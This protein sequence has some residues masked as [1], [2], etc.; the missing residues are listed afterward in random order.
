MESKSGGLRRT[1]WGLWA[2]ICIA[3]PGGADAGQGV[4]TSG[5]PYGGYM[6]TLAVDPSNPNA[7]Y[8]GTSGGGVYK[9]TNAGG[10]WAPANSGLTYLDQVSALVVDPTTPATVYAG[11]ASG[12]NSAGGIFRSTNAGGTWASINT[13]LL[14][15][16]VQA[17]AMALSTPATLYAATYGGLFKTVD[18]GTTWADTGLTT[19][20]V[21]AVVVNPVNPATLYAGT[22]GKVYKST[23]SGGT[24]V[25]TGLASLTVMALAIDPLTPTTLFAGT[26]NLGVLKSTDAG[27]TW[28][29]ANSGLPDQNVTG[30]A[31]NPQTPATLY[32][33][34]GGVK[35]Y[36]STDSGGTWVE[37]FS[38]SLTVM[39]LALNPQ[40][41]ATVYVGETGEG[42]RVHKSTD[43]GG[44]W[45]PVATGI[46][47]L[48]LQSIAVA[49]STPGT[50]YAG[51]DGGAFKS[52][53]SGGSWGAPNTSV[54]RVYALAVDPSNPARI[55]AGTYWGIRRSTDAG[56]T[57]ISTS[58]GASTNALA[59]DPS[60][61]NVV[62]A[63]ADNGRVYKSTDS[64]S[65]WAQTTLQAGNGTYALVIDPTAP[66]TIYA[67][68]SQVH[69]S[70]DAGTTWIYSGS[71]LS[72]NTLALAVD[73]GSSAILYAGK[74]EGV[75][76]STN[77]GSTW[78]TSSSG[79]P[80]NPYVVKLTVDPV[81]PSNVYAGT[82][83]G[84]TFKSS[85]AGGTWAP[86]SPGLPVPGVG[87]LLVDPASST[88]YVA[89]KYGSIWQ[90]T[91][92]PATL[93]VADSSALEAS[94]QITF[95][96]SLTSSRG[97]QVT[98]AYATSDGSARAGSD[99]TG[100][101]GVL[102]FPP[103]T[104]SRSVSVP[105]LNDAI[106]EPNETFYLNLS[107][108]S[109]VA[110]A[111]S[112]ATGTIINDDGAFGLSISGASVMEGNSGTAN[113]TFTVTLTP[114]ASSTVT[115]NYQTLSGTATV[116]TDFTLASG[117]LTF[118]PGQTSRPIV[119]P[120]V[121][122]TLPET[123][124]TFTVRL[125]GAVGAVIAGGGQ[126]VG[127]I[128]DDDPGGGALEVIDPACSSGT[129]CDGAV[130]SLLV[131]RT[132]CGQSAFLTTDTVKLQQASVT[133]R[134]VVADGVT[135]LLLRMPSSVPVTFSLRLHD[136]T[137][138][139]GEEVG[140]LMD[141]DAC[142]R[143]TSVTVSPELVSGSN[144][145]F[146][147]YQAPRWTIP[148]SGDVQIIATPQGGGAISKVVE[149]RRPPVVL[150]HGVWSGPDTWRNVLRPPAAPAKWTQLLREAGFDAAE[151][152]L[153]D[154]SATP[155]G[156]FDPVEIY[157]PATPIRALILATR[158]A[159][160]RLRAEHDA[161]VTQVDVVGHSLGGLVARAR[162]KY[163]PSP[164]YMPWNLNKGD[165]HKII[166]IGT[167]HQATP[168]GDLLSKWQC[169]RLASLVGPTLADTLERLDMPMGP[170]IF[171]FQ[172]S[173]W[174]LTIIGPTP[175]PGHS[176]AGT[177]PLISGVEN[178]LNGLLR[179]YDLNETV[180]PLL[181]GEGN[182]DVIVPLA[183]QRGGLS[184]SL[185]S[186]VGGV[187]HAGSPVDI[188]ELNSL[189]VVTEVMRV[190][191]LPTT[192]SNFAAF[193][194]FQRTGT[195]I[196]PYSCPVSPGGTTTSSG[197]LALTPS[198]GEVYRPG[199]PVPFTATL[200]G[201][202]TVDGLLVSLGRGLTT[203]AGPGPWSV[204]FTPTA[205]RGG[206]VDLVA[207]TYG[208]T[209]SY[210]ASTFI[211]VL[212]AGSPIRLTAAPTSMAF[213][214]Q[215]EKAQIHVSGLYDDG[216]E[217]D[218]TSAAAGTTYSSSN[219]AV[220]AVTADG[221]VEAL[222][223]GTA[224][225]SVANGTS[226]AS[227][228]VTVAITNAAPTLSA[229]PRVTM[230]PGQS[231][232]VPVSA[233]DPNGNTL[234]ITGVDLPPFAS[235][236]DH[237]DGTG[238]V[239]LQPTGSDIGTHS[240]LIAVTDDGTP[241]LGAMREL[242]V[243]VRSPKGD[244]DSDSSTDLVFRST[245]N[246]AQN[247]VWLMNGVARASE[248][249]IVPDAASASWKIRG[250]DDFDG[251]GINDLVFWNQATGQVEFWLMN[252]TAREGDPVPLSGGPT[253]ATNWDLA[254]TADFNHDSL[255]D[256]VWRNATSQKIVIW[257]MN[258]T[259]RTGAMIPVPDQAV[260]G[261][262][263]VVGA[264]DYNAD[265]NTD[266]LWYNP[267]SGK[268]VFWFMDAA[269]HRI[270][271]QFANP[272]NAGD[273]NW[274]VLAAGDYGVGPG[275]AEWTQ[276]VVWRN[277]TSGRYV[278]WYMDSAGNRTAGTFTN[279][280]SPASALDWTL[281]GPR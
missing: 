25:D 244:M 126:G 165:I 61:S 229:L 72:T 208:G 253:L 84:G 137:P 103:G 240:L 169:K 201:G 30:F 132:T 174:P 10:T 102:T 75:F 52:T 118:A 64:G 128:T 175:V 269:V 119:V 38:S 164:Y 108:A 226:T 14:N 115:V 143:G 96:V 172:T 100:S 53:D 176:V 232:D 266:F 116:G 74:Y 183:S 204:T 147:A 198:A 154:Y 239:R 202:A 140:A 192:P 223:N 250:V 233:S 171:G 49:P 210:S 41:P 139:S 86:V 113:A 213:A 138:P 104:T 178:F 27:G 199:E 32:A 166:T 133:R 46:T 161:A 249:P 246:G 93:T 212:P 245:V 127:T 70:T 153:A 214:V 26:N 55:Y 230:P 35:V 162:V 150:V 149:L 189:D 157:G 160:D 121:G 5:G 280:I 134:A 251:D 182:H 241:T 234:S 62:Y 219:P 188:G 48:D 141:R 191:D 69:K 179:I 236:I 63:G 187:T 59:V 125:S 65:T 101:S 186:S 94:G 274:K 156:N 158:C 39:A 275:G 111:D 31:I 155:A 225:I 95:T 159:K 78:A 130:S 51:G 88:L 163:M 256:I 148:T 9:S 276:D 238:V 12:T 184:G 217:Y 45:T 120:V 124:E 185:S 92:P 135:L 173:S 248:G 13:G 105:I 270:T 205:T 91:P 123:N 29:A 260:D 131:A 209:E 50:M 33:K 136:G 58:V 83:N 112:R 224:T 151:E 278:V 28:V 144:Y 167:P 98:V 193:P 7:L 228:A 264:L 203:L 43:A 42:G 265:G 117:A 215:G 277:E 181:G 254:A 89:L 76:K 259:A 168:F 152:C 110:I 211:L 40:A 90:W 273:N 66:A 242:N 222:G 146:A 15:T 252:G 170:A 243:Q 279:P 190:L 258:G 36:K 237:G 67:S 73:P 221:E 145:V 267:N 122:D 197:M 8:A 60:A 24:W 56:T 218:L 2:A 109:G 200:T 3:L 271:G 261:N 37:T 57:W 87:G 22:G 206:R 4:W 77:A 216:G 180:D 21:W 99:Y 129:Q 81:N 262:W 68:G 20:P 281:V 114:A 19:Q 106:G 220:A 71:G 227:V 196:Q 195:Y 47:N 231:R 263:A 272:P 207:N 23:D 255:P 85:D 18:H 6:A 177:A 11:T 247:M 97:S 257:T 194:G 235:V 107:N 268:I 34:V 142:N 16:R 79:L 82:F 44:T 80:V 1:G 17:I 54:T